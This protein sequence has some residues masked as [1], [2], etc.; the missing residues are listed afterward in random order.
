M[1]FQEILMTQRLSQKEIA[2]IRKE[3]HN[4]RIYLTKEEKIEERYRKVKRQRDDLKRRLVKT[5]EI[6][7]ELQ[8]HI[9]K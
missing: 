5:Q 6:I 2:G 3:M 4:N 9:L 1:T 7:A 8:E